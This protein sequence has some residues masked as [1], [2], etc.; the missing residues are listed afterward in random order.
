MHYHQVFHP[1]ECSGF[2]DKL[3]HAPQLN[4]SANL[5]HNF[6]S[7]LYHDRNKSKGAQLFCLSSVYLIR[8]NRKES[9]VQCNLPLL[10]SFPRV[11]KIVSTDN[12]QFNTFEFFHELVRRN[13]KDNWQKFALT[14]QMCVR[15]EIASDSYR[16]IFN[17]FI[18]LQWKQ[19]AHVHNGVDKEWS[20]INP[21]SG[22]RSLPKPV[23]PSLGKMS[24]NLC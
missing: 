1:K 13:Y 18:Q 5:K 11:R 7:S 24:L 19:F 15:G 21:S 4:P 16:V 8:A 12:T 10:P 22:C 23:H 17:F 3:N 6:H 9:G 20:L 14:V 2:H